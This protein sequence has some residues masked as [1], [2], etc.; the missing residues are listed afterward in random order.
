MSAAEIAKIDLVIANRALAR[1]GA[2]DAYGHASVRHPSEPGRFFIS[3]SRSPQLVTRDDIMEFDFDGVAIGAD[4]RPA[5]SERFIHASLYAARPDVHAV[6][7]GHP[8]SLIPFS[9]GD[10]PVRPIF[11]TSDEFGDKVPVWD[12]RDEFGDGTDLLIRNKA[13]GDSLAR[14]FGDLERAVLMRGHGFAAAGRSAAHLMRICKALMENATVQLETMKFGKVTEMSPAEIAARR[15]T[16]GGLPEDHPSWMRGFEYEAAQVG[17]SELLA[18][19]AKLLA[20]A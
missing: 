19:R 6:M 9:V 13:H 11:F 14:A 18:E 10:I 17:L 4:N 1:M 8:L 12:M 15:R 7:H 16:L 2:V 3:C 5:Y 20:S